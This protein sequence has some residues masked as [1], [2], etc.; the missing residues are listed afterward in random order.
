MNIEMLDTFLDLLE[1]RNFN[2]TADNLHITQSTV[3]ARV[4]GLEEQLGVRLFVRGR[5]GAELMPEG[6]K[7]E[8]YA[9]NIRLGWNLARQELAM[10]SGYHGQLR[11]AMQVS[12]WDKL[13][14]DWVAELRRT[15]SD[16][17]VHV[18]SDYSRAMIDEI[19]FG[20][21]DVA[22]I[23]T[24][25]YRPELAVD[26][27]FDE[28]F[29]MVTTTP[30]ALED[31]LPESY[32]F[33]ASSPYFK[34]RHGELLPQLQHAPLSMG[35]SNMTIAYLRQHPGIAYLPE[36]MSRPLTDSGDLFP[37]EGAPIIDQPVYATYVSRH[38]YR[39]NVKHAL[40]LLSALDVNAP[41]IPE[42]PG[43]P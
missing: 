9:V 16:T 38:R 8:S 2:R 29:S 30:C 31:V 13:I 32:L 20:N 5:G 21:L 42:S 24:P 7:F 15:L 39:P 3:S 23:Y 18:E 19:V 10:P 25:E 1:T 40:A 11:V 33:V 14:T 6:Q 26:Y 41:G 34:A 28:R 4:R 43:D 37:V 27:L 12:L 36:R 17:A 35:L 22:V